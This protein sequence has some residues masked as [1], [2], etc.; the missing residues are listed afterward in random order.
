MSRRQLRR[1]EYRIH[2]GTSSPALSSSQH[3][4]PWGAWLGD[5]RETLPGAAPARADGGRET[6]NQPFTAPLLAA[7]VRDW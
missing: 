2:P 3:M 1:L 6:V 5:R 4:W 7:V